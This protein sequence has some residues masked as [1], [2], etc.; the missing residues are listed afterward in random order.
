[1]SKN[2][3]ILYQVLQYAMAVTDRQFADLSVSTLAYSFNIDR[4]KL[5]RQFKRRLGMTLQDFL[6]KEKMT[7]AAFLLKGQGDM[8]VKEISERIGFCTCDYFIRKFRKYYGV[9]PGRYKELKTT[10][11]DTQPGDQSEA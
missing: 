7:R 9:A 3:D 2:R 10:S 5:S 8:T 1:M 11:A 4:F 6:F